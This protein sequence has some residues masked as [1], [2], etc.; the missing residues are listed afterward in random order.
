MWFFLPRS[1]STSLD[2]DP[3]LISLSWSCSLIRSVPH[4]FNIFILSFNDCCVFLYYILHRSSPG[5]SVVLPCICLLITFPRH[6]IYILYLYNRKNSESIDIL[7]KS[8]HRRGKISL[9]MYKLL[10]LAGVGWDYLTH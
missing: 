5:L 7:N 8:Y 10:A 2:S 4:V 3:S 1:S 9:R 6:T